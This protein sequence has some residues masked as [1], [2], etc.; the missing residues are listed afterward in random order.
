MRLVPRPWQSW[1]NAGAVSVALLVAPTAFADVSSADSA[2][3][4]RAADREKREPDSTR[5]DDF[6]VRCAR[7]AP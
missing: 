2:D 1:L 3:T 4:L 7:S 6:G 5:R